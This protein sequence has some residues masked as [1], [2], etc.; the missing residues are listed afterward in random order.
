MSVGRYGDDESIKEGF[1]CQLLGCLSTQVLMLNISSFFNNFVL[2]KDSDMAVLI[3]NKD[4]ST[5]KLE[6][7]NLDTHG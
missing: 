2:A 6:R 3:K 5:Q 7:C 4:E 1:H